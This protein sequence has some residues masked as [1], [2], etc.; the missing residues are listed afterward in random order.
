MR[1]VC[2]GDSFVRGFGVKADENWVFLLNT[3]C[4]TFI[5]HG[6]CGDTTGGMLARFGCDVV[7]EKPNYLFLLGGLNDL[8][9]GSP[10]TT[11]QANYFAMV[12]QALHHGM[13]PVICTCPPFEP[14][15]ARRCW[16]ELTSFELIKRRYETLRDWLLSFCRSYKLAY[17]DF[18]GEFAKV[19]SRNPEKDWYLDGIHPTAE[20]HQVMRDIAVDA[21]R[22]L[23]L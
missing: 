9:A 2:F 12:H 22:Q 17:V 20:G 13:I 11:V 3:P 7:P 14:N 1:S 8:L 10:E 19:L 23:S 5:N 21:L 18:Y 15:A 6:I 4:S 16:P